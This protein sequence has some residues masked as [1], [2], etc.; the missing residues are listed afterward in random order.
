M[1][2]N[3]RATVITGGSSGLGLEIIKAGIGLTEPERRQWYNFSRSYSDEVPEGVNNCVGDVTNYQDI[4]D[5]A[6]RIYDDGCIVDQVINNAAIN[7]LS[8][9]EELNESLFDIVMATNVR[10]YLQVTKA[11]LSDLKQ[12][13]GVVCNI[14][15]NASH[16]PMTH[17][18]AYNASKG[19]AHIATLQMARELTREYGITVFGVSPAK[20]HG[21]EM[22]QHID[23]QVQWLRGWTQDEAEAYQ[24]D[25]LLR[26]EEIPPHVVAEFIVW[27][28]EQP[29]R[30]R[31]LTGCVLPYGA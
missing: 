25:A 21:T 20:L 7:H 9:F 26:R 31:W 3:S 13:Q 28:L 8:H 14:I 19:A 11:F 18:F 24:H 2:M 30:T 15:S 10:S 29:E 16:V 6:D 5:L 22:S 4:D 27:L 12:T 23:A 1:T 17:S